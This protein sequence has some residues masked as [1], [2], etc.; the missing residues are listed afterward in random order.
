MRMI[1]CCVPTPT[2]SQFSH[3]CAGW[4]PFE[5]KRAGI[6]T[7]TAARDAG[8]AA[9]PGANGGAAQV[10]HITVVG[11]GRLGDAGAMPRASGGAAV[12]QGRVRPACYLAP[13]PN[14][15][16][17]FLLPAAGKACHTAVQTQQL[18]RRAG[19][20]CCLTPCCLCQ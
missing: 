4:Q 3:S 12:L 16:R 18:C 20:A 6:A 15:T 17:V 11:A 10:P 8:D 2:S 19:C 7:V 1:V 9:R 13:R 5:P 14:S